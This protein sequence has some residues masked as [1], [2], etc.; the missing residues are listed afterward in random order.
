M[1]TSD[2]LEEYRESTSE[3]DEEAL[4]CNLSSGNILNGG[5]DV[6]SFNLYGDDL[7]ESSS[8][9]GISNSCY[10]M[11]VVV[12]LLAYY[13]CQPILQVTSGANRGENPDYSL[14]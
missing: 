7:R 4:V 6:T 1:N 2:E 3:M 13:I 5:S 12:Q 11:G 9:T 8:V 10:Q 14:S